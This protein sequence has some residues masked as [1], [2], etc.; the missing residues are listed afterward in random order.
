MILVLPSA[1]DLRD[2]Q[3]STPDD[4]GWKSRD[5]AWSFKFTDSSGVEPADVHGA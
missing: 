1:E 3:G 5:T 2:E 4:R